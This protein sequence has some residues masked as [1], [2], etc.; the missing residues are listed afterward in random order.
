MKER[1]RKKN[2]FFKHVTA[3]KRRNFEKKSEQKLL[4]WRNNFQFFMSSYKRRK[5]NKKKKRKKNKN[6]MTRGIFNINAKAFKALKRH[7]PS[8]SISLST[9]LSLSYPPHDSLINNKL[10]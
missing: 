1:E 7:F 3:F 4:F 6:R 5:F 10:I 8:L 2:T 9:S